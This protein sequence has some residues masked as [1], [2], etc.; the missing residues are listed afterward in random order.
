MRTTR[1][2]SLRMG[3]WGAAVFLAAALS[4][5]QTGT[6]RPPEQVSVSGSDPSELSRNPHHSIALDDQE[7]LHLVYTQGTE[8]NAPGTESKIYYRRYNGSNWSA[9]ERVDDA[10]LSDARRIG[11]RHPA[12]LISQDDDVLVTW[13][14]AR[15]T[16]ETPGNFINNLEIYLD[17]K[18]NGGTFTSTDYRITK[19]S[20]AHLGDNGY[21]PKIAQTPDERIWIAW[22]DFT[23]DTAIS[24]IYL[25]GSDAFGTFDPERSILLDR[26]TQNTPASSDPP[27]N[28]PDIATDG[29]GNVH[30]VF[31]V[32]TVGA[33]VVVY[34]RRN[35]DD[36]ITSPVTLASQEGG[37]FDPPKILA[38]PAGDVFVIWSDLRLSGNEELYFRRL[39]SGQPAFDSEV[40]LFS[41]S[42]RQRFPTAAITSSG[43]LALAW[44]DNRDGNFEIY[45]GEYDLAAGTMLFQRRVTNTTT[46]SRKPDLV[47]DSSDHRYL[48]WEESQNAL[49]TE[50]Y[51]TTTLPV[52]AADTH[53]NLYE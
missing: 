53:W 23:L 43:N 41:Q 8:A 48:V 1:I 45:D 29:S 50:I 38:S 46:E 49:S 19:T 3:M 44:A 36:T 4:H 5:A 31:S 33:G 17:R 35:S 6:Y 39:R 10:Y 22:H 40:K 42:A 9:P 37:F 2:E 12:L 34:A 20:A 16:S 11:G 26:L 24:D 15:N 14:D 51:F 13:Q 21:S 28:V 7:R 30:L 52:T 25:R 32:G 47:L 18:P 27:Y